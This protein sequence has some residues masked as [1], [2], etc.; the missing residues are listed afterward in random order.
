MQ[1]SR[2]TAVTLGVTPSNLEGNPRALASAKIPAPFH[3]CK[4]SRASK[5]VTAIHSPCAERSL[6]S[7]IVVLRGGAPPGGPATRHPLLTHSHRYRI[8]SPR[9]R[10]ITYLDHAHHCGASASAGPVRIGRKI[11]KMHC[12]SHFRHLSQP[13]HI[14]SSAH[15]TLSRSLHAFPLPPRTPPSDHHRDDPDEPPNT[16]PR[17]VISSNASITTK[18]AQELDRPD[19]HNGQTHPHQCVASST[20]PSQQTKATSAAGTTLRTHASVKPTH[21]STQPPPQLQRA[22]HAW[23]SPCRTAPGSPVRSCSTETPL[24]PARTSCVACTLVATGTISVSK[25]R[26]TAVPSCPPPH[27]YTHT[28]GAAHA[29]HVAT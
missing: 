26:S 28:S 17:S 8:I 22:G 6:R 3:P 1:T 5:R 18:I 16:P 20:K 25:R 19:G 13:P 14:T 10:A 11:K 12:V 7:L 4:L 29:S 15:G 9:G 2:K 27:A 24:L 23:G 21:S